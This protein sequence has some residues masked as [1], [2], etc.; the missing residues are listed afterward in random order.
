MRWVATLSALA[1]AGALGVVTLPAE[2]TTSYRYWSYWHAESGSAEWGYATEGSGTRIPDDGSVEGWRFGIAADTDR[3]QP[4]IDP[5][6]AT[7]CAGV[8]AVD[9]HKRVAIVIDPGSPA[10]APE[11]EAPGAIETTCILAAPSATG[12]QLLQQV[13]AVRMDAGF[14]CGI[15]GYPAQEC[16]PLVTM[17]DS[18]PQPL[19]GSTG[20]PSTATTASEET[21]RDVDSGT[22]LITAIALSILALV[23][24]GVWRHRRRVNVR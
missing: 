3:S 18:S 15:D 10:E 1:I 20:E 22:P 6:F 13:K 16:A 24:F 11:G 2:A 23:G 5:D 17:P 8:E 9:G 14:V 21:G 19:A 12:L 7:A 4:G